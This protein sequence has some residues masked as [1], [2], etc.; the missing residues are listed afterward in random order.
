MCLSGLYSLSNPL[1]FNNKNIHRHKG[2]SKTVIERKGGGE[3]I[4]KYLAQQQDGN[5]PAASLVSPGISTPPTP[6]PPRCPLPV[7][8]DLTPAP[9]PSPRANG[10]D[11][12]PPPPP[13]S[14]LSASKAVPPL[15]GSRSRGGGWR[16]GG[17]TDPRTPHLASRFW[18]PPQRRGGG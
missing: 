15:I 17:G 6:P 16:G 1:R 13:A 4:L 5:Q 9:P 10:S 3:M 7:P 11:D 2:L 8:L 14:H 12:S 18:V